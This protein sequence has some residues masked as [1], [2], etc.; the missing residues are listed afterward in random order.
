M[1][2]DLA[3]EKLIVAEKEKEKIAVE[4][5]SFIRESNISEFHTAVGQYIN[6]RKALSI[7]QPR[8]HL[9]LGCPI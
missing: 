1:Y 7:E 4:V 8:S 2:V 3:A 6:Y 9:V 5:K